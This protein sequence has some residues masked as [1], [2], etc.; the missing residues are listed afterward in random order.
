VYDDSVKYALLTHKF[1]GKERDAESGLDDFDARYYS[2]NLGRFVS[3]DWS[4]TPVPVPYADFNDPQS[5]NLYTYVRNL[6]TV[7]VD[8]NGHCGGG[9]APCPTPPG[10]PNPKVGQVVI[11]LVEIGAG[12]ATGGA[13]LELESAV[14]AATAGVSAAGLGV[15]GTSRIVI[16]S[17]GGTVKDA[18]NV[19]KAVT[20]VTNPVG[21]ATTV[22][23]GGNLDAGSKA[24][25]ASDVAKLAMNPVKAA[26][27]DPAGT[28]LTVRSAVQ[29]S[30]STWTTIKNWFTSPA[31]P[32]KPAA[33][34]P[35]KAA[36]P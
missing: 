33:P 14:A 3:A 13:S 36:A 11:G 32:P 2:S 10:T 22:V 16:V 25:T 5:L 35:P 20:T 21:L 30:K 7:K 24:A 28:A 17:T 6:P 23:T 15:S 4:A 9:D 12:I 31:P 18:E 8:A 1:T 34:A 27:T 26:T 29:E 19:S